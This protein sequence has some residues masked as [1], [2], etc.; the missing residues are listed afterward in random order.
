MRPRKRKY[1]AD[2]LG[3]LKKILFNSEKM[4]YNRCNKSFG[5]GNNGYFQARPF[6]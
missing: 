2:Q 4:W 1:Y 6:G 5:E 3:K